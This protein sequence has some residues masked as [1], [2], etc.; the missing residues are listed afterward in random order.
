M[1]T[2]NMIETKENTIRQIILNIA[3]SSKYSKSIYKKYIL[4][5]KNFEKYKVE[6][7]NAG[8]S[9]IE[10]ALKSDELEGIKKDKL[11]EYIQTDKMPPKIRPNVE[12]IRNSLVNIINE[13]NI[14]IPLFNWYELNKMNVGL[15]D[16]LKTY[17][18]ID[19]R[20]IKCFINIKQ[21]QL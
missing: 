5:S 16:I 21:V 9:I 8:S 12:A 2:Q 19:N 3:H 14:S 13:K 7:A 20:K 6:V 4:A 10:K 18:L 1:T 15:I 11:I 17:N